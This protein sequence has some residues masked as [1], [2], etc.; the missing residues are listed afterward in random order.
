MEK[1]LF[2]SGLPKE[3]YADLEIIA[4]NPTTFS[5]IAS[6]SDRLQKATKQQDFVEI[7]ATD[8]GFPIEDAREVLKT[9]LGLVHLS[10]SVELSTD[11]FI[12]AFS[13][14]IKN[15][16]NKEW[17][18]KH[19]EGWEIAVQD[20]NLLI[21]PDSPLSIHYKASH[22]ALRHKHLWQQSNIYTDI[23][24]VFN[25]AGDEVL[26]AVVNHLLI[27]DYY[28]TNVD[29]FRKKRISITMDAEDI[30]SLLHQCE[31]AMAKA[32]ATVNAFECPISITGE[33]DED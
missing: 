33:T 12:S 9:I 25:D 20:L 4:K 21:H 29:G 14:L 6:A 7:I 11:E 26:R 13:E 17:L 27:V 22:L 19:L 8:T 2:P 5:I 30:E 16:D 3:V 18:N 31:R 28:S 24:P 23:R 15:G 10:R 32:K 1:K